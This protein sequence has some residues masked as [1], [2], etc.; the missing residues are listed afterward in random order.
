[1]PVGGKAERGRQFANR[2]TTECIGSLSIRHLA[3]LRF[4]RRSPGGFFCRFPNDC[5]AHT[6]Y[7]AAARRTG[8]QVHALL[9]P[10]E[11]LERFPRTEI[12]LGI[13]L[14]PGLRS[15]ARILGISPARFVRFNVSRCALRKR[16]SF[17]GFQCSTGC[18]FL[19]CLNGV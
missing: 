6:T 19:A 5:D 12:G 17:R 18:F 11:L 13:S 2:R 7:P 14:G 15:V 1:M 8:A 4:A 9:G 16:E 3:L 10:Q